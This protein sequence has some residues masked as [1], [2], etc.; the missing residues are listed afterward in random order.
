MAHQELHELHQLRDKQHECEDDESEER[1]TEYFANDIA[2]KNAH[3]AKR[4]CSTAPVFLLVVTMLEHPS[5]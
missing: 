5:R 2:I 3:G 1:M 4:E